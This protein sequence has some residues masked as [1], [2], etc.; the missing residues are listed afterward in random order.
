M[1]E[2]RQKIIATPV[3]NISSLA[4]RLKGVGD[5]EVS[6]VFSLL[7][8]SAVSLES[9]DIHLESLEHNVKIRLRIDGI[10]QDVG[11]ISLKLYESLLSRIKLTSGI[12]LN[13]SDR[14]QD[15]RFSFELGGKEGLI[16]IRSSTLPSEYGESVVLRILNPKS[17][18]TLKDLG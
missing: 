1:S 15:G 13:V 16:E 6:E 2:E 7:L 3:Q 18:L 12:K 14:P 5:S 8:A 11:I 17:L 9:S 4:E 10:L